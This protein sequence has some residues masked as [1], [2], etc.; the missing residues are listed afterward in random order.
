MDSL[1]TTPEAVV[2]FLYL[3]VKEDY[4]GE[5]VS[6]RGMIRQF[7]ACEKWEQKN[8]CENA[9]FWFSQFILN[10]EK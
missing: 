10:N 1:V 7:I 4:R 9:T 6:Y 8:M 3:L 5:T 2:W